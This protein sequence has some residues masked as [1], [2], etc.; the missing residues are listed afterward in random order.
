MHLSLSLIKAEFLLE[1]GLLASKNWFSSLS[2]PHSSIAFV[3]NGDY[4]LGIT[5]LNRSE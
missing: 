3:P 2:V 5:I 4:G 1:R